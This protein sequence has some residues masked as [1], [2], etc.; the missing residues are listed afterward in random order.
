M[1]KNSDVFE[2]INC[3]DNLHWCTGV[4]EI[5]TKQRARITIFMLQQ[6]QSCLRKKRVQN[7]K[8]AQL[9]T[10]YDKFRTWCWDQ[11]NG[12]ILPYITCR[13]LCNSRLGFLLMSL[14]Q[15]RYC[16]VQGI[17]MGYKNCWNMMT[18]MVNIHMAY[19]SRYDKYTV[20]HRT[21]IIY[22]FICHISC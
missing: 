10:I 2:I 6:F 4:A 19:K 17:E 8:H 20:K 14:H 21:F 13:R 12:D 22:T 9:C 3:N 16:F 1:N 5:A 11:T 15:H 7:W 18:N